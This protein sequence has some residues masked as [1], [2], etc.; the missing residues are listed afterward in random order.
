MANNITLKVLMSA[1]EHYGAKVAA[2]AH[3]NSRFEASLDID[4]SRKNVEAL[5]EKWG[6]E[7][8]RA[9]VM[10]GRTLKAAELMLH[11]EL[12]EIENRELREELESAEEAQHETTRVGY[13]CRACLIGRGLPVTVGVA[14]YPAEPVGWGMNF[15]LVLFLVF[16]LFLL[17]GWALMAAIVGG[18][19]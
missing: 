15:K 2:W 18:V 7:M 16:I 4:V 13:R 1:V 5:T 3:S 8:W 17:I 11:A 12:L 19:L 14:P 6:E 9:G 10:T